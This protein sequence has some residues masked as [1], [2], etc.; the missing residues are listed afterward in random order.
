MA[1]TAIS[2]A[3]R[4][5]GI[6]L[7]EALS[8]NEDK[9]IIDECEAGEDAAVKSYRE[10]LSHSLPGNVTTIVQRQYAGVLEVHGVL[11]NLKHGRA[12]AATSGS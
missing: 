10:A 5:C 11:S 12:A 6:N 4:I 8:R 2:P 7:K 3:V 1:Y 9:A